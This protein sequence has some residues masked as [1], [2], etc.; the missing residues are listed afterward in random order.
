VQI[1]KWVHSV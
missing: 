1:E